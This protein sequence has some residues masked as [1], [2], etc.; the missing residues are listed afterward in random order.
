MQMR[1]V[2]RIVRD[3]GTSPFILP[4]DWIIEKKKRSSGKSAHLFDKVTPI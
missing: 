4:D 2:P 3:A 1:S